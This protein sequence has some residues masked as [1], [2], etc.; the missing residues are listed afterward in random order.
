MPEE[1]AL[2]LAEWVVAALVDE[3]PRHGFAIAALTADDG[4]LGRV[5]RVPRP[6]VYRAIGRLEDLL[7]IEVSG[8]EDG[9]R[10]PQRSV[11]T[12]TGAG[13]ETVGAWLARPVRHVRDV[14]SELLVKLALLRRRRR[15]TARLVAA[16]RRVITGIDAALTRQADDASGFDAVLARWRVENARAVLRFLDS[17]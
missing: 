13:S 7:L 14:R 17:L 15:G 9:A 8:T 2:S 3:Q 16:Q 11:L 1:P 12:T 5:W 4:E 6:V 10:G